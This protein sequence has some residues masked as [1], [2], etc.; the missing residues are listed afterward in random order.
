MATR[1]KIDNALRNVPMGDVEKYFNEISTIIE[2]NSG[3][4]DCKIIS[5]DCDNTSAPF[6]AG[7]FTKFKL[8]DTAMD[9]V[10]LSKG[11]ITMDVEM[12]VTFDWNPQELWTTN[13]SNFQKFWESTKGSY[14]YMKPYYFVGFKS[15][16]HILE[17]YNV[18]SNG[19]LTNCKQ[20]HAKEEQ[21]IV[22]MSKSKEERVGRPGMY[23]THEAVREMSDCV[24]GAYIQAPA[25]NKKNEPVKIKF[26]VLIQIDDLLPFSA[27]EYYPRFL[28]GD[29]ELQISTQITQ[30]MVWCQLPLDVVLKHPELP[31]YN[32]SFGGF[33]YGPECLAKLLGDGHSDLRFTQC[34]D[35]AN[36]FYPWRANYDDDKLNETFTTH[37]PM[38]IRTSNL[39]VTE[40][41]S[42]I[43]GFNIKNT[44]KQNLA[45]MFND[46][47]LVIPSQTI[48][49]YT[50]S[51]LPTL[52]DIR[53]NMQLSMNNACQ[54]IMTFPNTAN[55][56]TV[57]RNPH[58]EAVQ[59]QVA[60]RIVP[61]KFFSTLD[62][63]HSEMIIE[64]LNFDSLFSAPDELIEA[65]TKDRGENGTITAHFKDDSDYMLVI[66]L[67][68]FGNGCYCDGLSG[69]NIPINLQANFM[70]GTKNPHFYKEY[71]TSSDDAESTSVVNGVRLPKNSKPKHTPQHINVFVVS[72][73]FWVCNRNGCEFVTNISVDN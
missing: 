21:T 51:Q 48:S 1:H 71:Y 29:L 23:S 67:E 12:D 72:D 53:A 8:T 45:N 56:L 3:V 14:Y 46:K 15:G 35:Y 6:R 30:N 50:F 70:Y 9:I 60:D 62:K 27:C 38:T 2:S 16:A 61:D 73:A 10:D 32:S 4:H 66:N 18:Y 54:L 40:A 52:R 43:H 49:H 24:C 19:V 41:K 17:V 39:S 59:C 47:N 36:T 26:T 37:C 68:R 42:Y 69:V 44:V 65:L 13:G 25:L 55:Q 58:L 33:A 31:S 5:H 7:S 63:A 20:T 34:G 22:Y 11:Y 64:N 28:T 57:S